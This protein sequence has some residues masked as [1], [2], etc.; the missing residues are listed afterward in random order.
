MSSLF[1]FGGRGRGKEFP[2]QVFVPMFPPGQAILSMQ[3]H[4]YSAGHCYCIVQSLASDLVG[5]LTPCWHF[6]ACGYLSPIF[7]DSSVYN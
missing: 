6:E 7:G 2:S 4:L 5:V 1:F 3:Y